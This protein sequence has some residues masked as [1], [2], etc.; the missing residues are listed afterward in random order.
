MGPPSKEIQAELERRATE[1]FR[2]TEAISYYFQYWTPPLLPE[3]KRT[4]SSATADDYQLTCQLPKLDDDWEAITMA[5]ALIYC[6]F[7]GEMHGWNDWFEIQTEA[8]RL[9][10]LLHQTLNEC[11]IT[12]ITYRTLA[13]SGLPIFKDFIYKYGPKDLHFTEMNKYEKEKWKNREIDWKIRYRLIADLF[14]DSSTLQDFYNTARSKASSSRNSM[15]K[16]VLWAFIKFVEERLISNMDL[17]ENIKKE[18]LEK[19]RNAK[20]RSVKKDKHRA[21]RPAVC[22]SD[23]ECGQILYSLINDFLSVKRPNKKSKILAE[24]IIFI[25]IAQHGGF[26]DIPLKGNDIFSIKTP[27]FN[28]KEL[29]ITA[30]GREIFITEGLKEVI[31]SY[32]GPVKRKNHRS[33][34]QKL[35]YDN[36]EEIL[37]KHSTKLYGAEWRLTPKDFLEKV[38][39]IQGAR[40]TSDLRREIAKQEKLVKESPYRVN[41]SKIKKHIHETFPKKPS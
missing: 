35:T 29:T 18:L 24:A 1:H 19:L 38:Y 28:P 21:K 15:I 25:W 13:I 2:S 8:I 9:T 37:D 10:P 4:N 6:P 36:L 7:D 16:F 30:N 32:L 41:N 11:K 31:S 34:F 26:S 23:F 20:K 3:C 40:I 22:I 5:R 12:Q 14:D 39:V 27:D 33:L 17:S